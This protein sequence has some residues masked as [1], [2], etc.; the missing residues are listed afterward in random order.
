MQSM[1]L[2]KNVTGQFF[3]SSVPSPAEG[4]RGRHSPVER[5]GDT[6]P[7]QFQFQLQAGPLDRA[8]RC[9]EGRA[10][11]SRVVASSRLFAI[12]RF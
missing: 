7:I 6:S 11:G 2:E 1:P 12:F 10:R 4:L 3:S 9:T 5:R 8:A